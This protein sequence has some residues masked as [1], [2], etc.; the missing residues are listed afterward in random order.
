MQNAA[1][2]ATLV[3]RNHRLFLED[4][5]APPPGLEELVRG[6][7]PDDAAADDDCSTST[8]RGFRWPSKR[9]QIG[10]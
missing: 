8:R 7:Q 4:E 5:D 2:V 9:W 10:H 1:V 6:R 3:P